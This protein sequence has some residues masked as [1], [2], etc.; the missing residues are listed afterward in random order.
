MTFDDEF[1]STNNAEHSDV[2]TAK[3]N[4]AN[5]PNLANEEQEWYTPDNVYQH[6]GFLVLKSENR[7]I[8]G[9]PFASGKVDTAGKWSPHFGRIE[10]RAK[11]PT[12]KGIWPAH[13]MLGYKGW[14]PELDITELVGS[15]PYGNV[16]SLHY[17]PLPSWCPDGKPWNCGHTH[18]TTIYWGIDWTAD[19]HTFAFEWDWWYVKWYIDGALVYSFYYDIPDESM[20]LILNTA[21]GGQWPGWPD[22]TTQWP[23]YHLIDYVRG[24]IQ[25]DGNSLPNGGFENV[26]DGG[27]LDWNTINDSG[28]I[29]TNDALT[30]ARSGARCAKMFGR[31]D[32]ETNQSFLVQN[33]PAYEGQMWQATVWAANRRFDAVQGRNRARFK[34]EFVDGFGALQTQYPVTV[35]TSNTP[36]SY[37]QYVIRQKAPAWT[38]HA[39]IVMEYDQYD[40]AAGSALFDDAELVPV[41]VQ[42]AGSVRRLVNGSFEQG[43]GDD[44]L[45]WNTYG[46]GTNLLGATV[47]TNVYDGK[48]SARIVALADGSVPQTGLFQDIP[49]RAGEQW[50]A[51]VWAQ[52]NPD[53]PLQGAN[54]G[55]L[56]LEYVNA[57]GV[58]IQSNEI[59]VVDAASPPG[60]YT[61]AELQ[62]LAPADTAYARVALEHRQAT[63]GG[64]SVQ[65]DQATLSTGT[66][67]GK[68]LNPELEFY[69]GTNFIG[70]SAY[71]PLN[72]TW[73]VIQDPYAWYARSGDGALQMFG[74]F[75]A[76]ASQ[77]ESGLYQDIA[78]HSGEVWQATVW[79]RN[80]PGDGVQ[81]GNAARL[82]L[83]FLDGG[84]VVLDRDEITVVTSNS[85]DFYQPFVLRRCAPRWTTKAR[86]A[87]AYVQKNNANGSA[88]FDDPEL[89]KVGVNDSVPTLNA[90]FEDGAAEAFP[91]W[92][93]FNTVG[94]VIHETNTNNIRTGNSAVQLYGN[95]QSSDNDSGVFQDY[96]AEWLQLWQ[97]TVW[98]KNRE[99]DQLWGNNTATLKIEF[100]DTNSLILA[101]NR[102]TIL[103]TGST[104]QWQPF[105]IRRRAPYG[106]SRARMVI[107]MNQRSYNPGSV[108]FDDAQMGVLAATNAYRPLLNGGFEVGQTNEF[109]EWI[110]WAPSGSTVQNVARDT[111]SFNARSGAKCLQLYGAF[112]GG[113]NSSGLFQDIPA[114][115]G[116]MW[117]ASA[118][119]RNRPGDALQGSNTV[120]LKLEFADYWGNV[121]QGDRIVCADA[122]SPTNYQWFAIRNTAPQGT[123]FARITLQY[124]QIN[125]ALGAANLDDTDLRLVTPQSEAIALNGG[126]EYRGP[127]AA[128]LSG[129]TK[130]GGVNNVL[131]D[132]ATNA[133]TGRRAMQVYGQF[134][135][136]ANNSGLFQDIPAI[137]GQTWQASVWARNRPGDALQGANVGQLKLEFLDYAGQVLHE[138]HLVT[139]TA[140]STTN[141]LRHAIYRQAPAGTT[142]ARIALEMVQYNYAGGSVN[143]DDAALIQM[144]A[145]TG[146]QTVNVALLS[147]SHSP[148]L[149]EQTYFTGRLVLDPSANLDMV[150]GGAVPGL[151]YDRISVAS[152]AALSGT[153]TVVMPSS[154]SGQNV[155]T[156]HFI[157]RKGD[158]FELVSAGQ[159]SGSFTG[160]HSPTG[161]GGQP[162]FT[163]AY[164]ST[165]VSLVVSRELDADGDGLADYWE[166]LYFGSPN[167][168][169]ASTDTDQDNVPNRSEMIAGTDPTNELSYLRLTQMDAGAGS[170]GLS[171]NS[172]TGKFY[173]VW[174]S[175]NL[176]G[177]PF[178]LVTNNVPATEPLNTL[179]LPPAT[180]DARFL[181][182]GVR[183]PAFE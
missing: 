108:V 105:A 95:F 25:T 21:V 183:D 114:S 62:V 181:R 77:N 66:D 141:Y 18:N 123:A 65:F 127:N 48:R 51:K 148:G 3:W 26:E 55:V 15:N 6:N 73:N 119:A 158:R 160:L 118:W 41:T 84:N 80:R 157:P 164:T 43:D 83:E 130:Y 37:T 78:A 151:E 140:A 149:A 31:F 159:V 152:T 13:W 19:W 86:I 56:K 138:D 40:Y 155:S 75:P 59:V 30:D 61:N 32:S 94:N 174:G 85:P 162:A 150:V 143:F 12:G 2:N 139:T 146:T 163:L 42:S 5:G 121:I 81:G 147:G 36:A 89:V 106:T 109:G 153:L 171:W 134:N 27:F 4:I 11:L 154:F 72:A 124:D 177:A 45:S 179:T 71:A 125:D 116:E 180:N 169:N 101:T 91:N 178:A 23:Q 97:A 47:A 35:V 133:A 49:S 170:S 14:P 131:L 99:G 110:P 57:A 74:H 167:N 98:G 182:L 79:A 64:G 142:K 52:N 44:F 156:N 100:Y 82:K 50:T 120:W 53:D 168:G 90:G 60:A 175:T 92:P 113:T 9:W 76:D 173:S 54:E 117:E 104:N 122:T 135:S 126:F 22:W 129:W 16:V 102:L 93:Q 8:N 28:N 20:F 88:N 33:L 128:D 39:R 46:A 136:A 34:L 38:T 17:G 29:A 96:P 24:W 58:V 7:S 115:A 144:P 69:D 145:V 161:L 111:N 112:N 10:I 68:L 1:N 103:N 176:A 132:P 67:L 137:E 87:L 172:V 107:E 166:Q 165:N 70:W 63:G